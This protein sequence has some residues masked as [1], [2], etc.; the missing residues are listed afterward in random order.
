LQVASEKRKKNTMLQKST[1][2]LGRYTSSAYKKLA[3]ANLARP[4]ELEL[5]QWLDAML[6]RFPNSRRGDVESE[7]LGET[8]VSFWHCD[9]PRETLDFEWGV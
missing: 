6:K 2:M 7:P 4:W 9:A 8:G 3:K 5:S 1:D